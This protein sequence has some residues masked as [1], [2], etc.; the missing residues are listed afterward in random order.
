MTC[1]P[2]VDHLVVCIDKEGQQNTFNVEGLIIE[3]YLGIIVLMLLDKHIMGQK[4]PW[5]LTW[6]Y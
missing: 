2:D 1:L 4:L 3:F 6:P 5:T